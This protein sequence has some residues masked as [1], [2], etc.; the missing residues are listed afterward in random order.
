MLQLVTC[1]KDS[2]YSSLKINFR[3]ARITKLTII[4]CNFNYNS[5]GFTNLGALF[6]IN[7]GPGTE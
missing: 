6:D 2:G 1:Q 5:V 4:F 7:E 3:R